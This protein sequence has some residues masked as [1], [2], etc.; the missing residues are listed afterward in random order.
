MSATLADQLQHHVWKREKQSTHRKMERCYRAGLSRLVPGC[1]EMDCLAHAHFIPYHTMSECADRPA[2]ADTG[3][4]ATL[5]NTL[6]KPAAEPA[7]FL[8]IHM[9]C[10]CLVI[11]DWA[12]KKVQ[13]GVLRL[14][15]AYVRA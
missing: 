5:A 13:G 15:S 4:R 10:S 9:S 2:H 11:A 1:P 7:A 12:D 6:L 8:E 3:G 14:A